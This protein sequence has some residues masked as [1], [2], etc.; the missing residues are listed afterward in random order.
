MDNLGISIVLPVYNCIEYIDQS[1]LSVIKQKNAEFEL[2]IV[3]DGS[4]D[5][6]RDIV[7]AYARQYDYIKVIHNDHK[8]VNISRLTGLENARYD[9]VAFLD[10]DDW[11]DDDYLKS[12]SAE[13]IKYPKTDIVIGECIVEQQNKTM[14]K[15]NGIPYGYYEND[16][17]IDFHSHMLCAG[18]GGF[19]WGILP[20]LWNKVFKKKMLYKSYSSIDTRITDGEDVAV[21]ESYMSNCNRILVS[22]ISK[23]HY[24][25]HS[26]QVTANKGDGFYENVCRLY[27]ELLKSTNINSEFLIPQADEYLR[28]MVGMKKSHSHTSSSNDK[29]SEYI[30][31]LD[32]SRDIVIVGC[33]KMGRVLNEYIDKT[34]RRNNVLCFADNN[35]SACDDL[36]NDKRVLSV[37][38]A[39]HNYPDCLF[40]V[41]PKK[42]R[43]NL[44]RQLVAEGIELNQIEIFD[45]ENYGIK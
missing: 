35:S 34:P 38:N 17:I 23:Y 40:I 43:M 10:A 42:D 5:G 8:G 28:Y 13:I 19:K 15:R 41:T 31:G 20:Y 32:H 3:D 1:V 39:V 21:I 36:I 6:T 24:R 26:K 33:G 4:D 14:L 45:S 30:S 27:L 37:R 29:I 12:Y 25:M 2:I 9:W 18:E 22:P 7:D 11:Y 16:A 44:I